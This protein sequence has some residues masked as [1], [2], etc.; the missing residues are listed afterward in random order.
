LAPRFDAQIALTL[1]VAALCEPLEGVI[2]LAFSSFSSSP[3]VLL[4]EE[5]GDALSGLEKLASGDRARLL[6]GNLT[7]VAALSARTLEA[8]NG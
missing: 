2:K 7:T 3:R 6:M 8:Q 4:V 5:E 1:S